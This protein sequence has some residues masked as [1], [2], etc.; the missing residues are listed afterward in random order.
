MGYDMMNKKTIVKMDAVVI[1]RK[2][3]QKGG[4]NNQS[5]S[6]SCPFYSFSPRW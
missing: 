4:C 5:L 6:L 1:R 3:E 2:K